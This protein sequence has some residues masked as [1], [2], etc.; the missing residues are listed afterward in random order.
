MQ[1]VLWKGHKWFHLSQWFYDKISILKCPVGASKNFSQI[2]CL[3]CRHYCCAHN[4]WGGCFVTSDIDLTPDYNYWYY[5]TL[6]FRLQVPG[7][8]WTG[9]EQPLFSAGAEH[10]Y[11]LL[12]SLGDGCF[13]FVHCKSHG[14]LSIAVFIDKI[15]RCARGK[16]HIK[17]VKISI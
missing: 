16:R 13:V 5:Q 1:M 10:F 14:T 4:S 6:L 15:N 9:N 11:L 7:S 3:V 2:L 17:G 8:E 12:S